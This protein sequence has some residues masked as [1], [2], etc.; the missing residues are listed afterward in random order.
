MALTV[1]DPTI[2]E[3][4]ASFFA[5]GHLSDHPARGAADRQTI[6]AF[7][8]LRGLGALTQMWPAM[9]TYTVCSLMAK[10]LKRMAREWSW[11]AEKV[12]GIN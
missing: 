11:F 1:G 4:N 12:N 6:F 5:V 9:V 10:L 3:N 2:R 7:L 8:M